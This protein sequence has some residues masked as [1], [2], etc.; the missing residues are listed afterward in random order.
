MSEE[1]NVLLNRWSTDKKK[2]DYY[3]I[4]DEILFDIPVEKQINFIEYWSETIPKLS[5]D[6]HY[7]DPREKR[8]ISGPQWSR[9]R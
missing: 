3:T 2:R 9:K 6:Y 5:N 4:L 1:L 7:S 8:R